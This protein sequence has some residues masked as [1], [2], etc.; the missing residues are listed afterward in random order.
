MK[1]LLYH[2][3]TLKIQCTWTYILSRFSTR[4][5]QETTMKQSSRTD[6][7]HA[8]SAPSPETLFVLSKLRSKSW[9]DAEWCFGLRTTY[10]NWQVKKSKSVCVKKKY[11]KEANKK[12]NTWRHEKDL[13]RKVNSQRQTVKQME[14][15]RNLKKNN[16]GHIKMRWNISCK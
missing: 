3:C 2:I 12:N 7:Q 9:C 16:T 15:S 6:T 1:L 11:K 14:K 10:H 4:N 13:M 5:W 8:R